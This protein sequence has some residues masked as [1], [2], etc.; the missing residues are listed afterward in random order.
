MATFLFS[1]SAQI[2]PLLLAGGSA[3]LFQTA[4]SSAPPPLKSKDDDENLKLRHKAVMEEYGLSASHWIEQHSQV[5]EMG[6]DRHFGVTATIGEPNPTK[7]LAHASKEHT[8]LSEHNRHNTEL[9]MHA[10]KGDIRPSKRTPIVDGLQD[11]IA[12]P[13]DPAARSRFGPY[14]HVVNHPN[15][16]QLKQ[17]LEKYQ[18]SNDPPQLSYIRKNA[19]A[20]VPGLGF[21]YEE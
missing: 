1:G 13:N 3:I 11:E 8:D 4:S 10:M 7:W 12:H 19:F 9:F 21:R 20:R 17:G 16:T 18:S 6:T 5:S 2:L 14:R 15:P